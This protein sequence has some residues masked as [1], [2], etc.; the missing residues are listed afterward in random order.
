VF[1]VC[2]VASNRTWDPTYQPNKAPA[3]ETTYTE[4]I[5]AQQSKKHYA[6]SSSVNRSL[7]DSTSH[8][9]IPSGTARV[10]ILP[11]DRYTQMAP[12]TDPNQQN[13]PKKR[14]KLYN[15]SDIAQSSEMLTW[16][17]Y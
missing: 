15:N 16:N 5:K 13:Q 11:L 9:S 7:A 6:S 12:E 17:S 8:I 2:A 4:A 3:F 1:V 10:D 14:K